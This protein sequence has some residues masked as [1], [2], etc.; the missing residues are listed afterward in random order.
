MPT[1]SSGIQ[2]AL[3][4]LLAQS[5]T[6][7]VIEHNVANA[8]TPGYRRQ[9]AVLSTSDPVQVY[10]MDRGFGA[11]QIGSGVTVDAIK[12]YSLNFFDDRYRSNSAE[13]SNLTTQKN[14][15]SQLEVTLSET[16]D[17]GLVNKLDGFWSSWQS[18]AADPSN[19]SLRSNV[20]SQAGALSTAFN[21]RAQQ[22]SALQADQNQTI[23]SRVDEINSVASQIAGLNG[24]IARI[25]SI[26]EHPNDLLDKRDLLLDRL[27]EIAGATSAVQKNGAV[28]VSIGQH[29][30]VTGQN[31]STLQ[32]APDPANS[33]LAQ[34]SWQDGKSFQPS[35]GELKGLLYARDSVIPDQ[36][37]RLDQMA[38]ILATNVNQI[39]AAGY[40]Q[41]GSTGL[42]FFNGTD[43]LSI[44]VNP[45]LTS[46]N[47]AVASSTD[48]AGN[49]D[50]AE[51]IAA[52]KS[53]KWMSGSTQTLSDFY[54]GQVAALG[55]LVQRVT[56]SAS[57]SKLVNSALDAQRESV[58]GVSLDEEAANLAKA[59]KAYQAA[60]RV[61]T[62]YD[63]LLDRIIN[64]MGISG[65]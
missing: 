61:M 21:Q 59:Q 34:I 47:M 63:E 2:V 17:N 10:G 14:V 62:I 26:G 48:E 49:G 52:M 43:A 25:N 32:A 41:D 13:T 4:A 44:Q 5:Q 29:F 64:G 51:A 38:K 37:A 3:S 28:V 24:E 18:L 31:T 40:G 46:T 55:Q 50:V 20:L 45:N 58:S 7:E 15:L 19:T 30:L 35:S 57:Q 60:A 8:N 11:G 36:R 54:T 39:H 53:S 16:T 23:S 27:S 42:N 65:R 1:L 22:L 6:I 33:N 12:S 9:S 56:D